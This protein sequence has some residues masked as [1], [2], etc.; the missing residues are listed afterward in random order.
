MDVYTRVHTAFSGGHLPPCWVLESLPSLP[1]AS[2]APAQLHSAASPCR[3]PGECWSLGSAR[4]SPSTRPRV[5]GHKPSH[6]APSSTSVPRKVFGVQ[7]TP[8]VLS[9][10]GHCLLQ[11][12]T[13]DGFQ[14]VLPPGP[15]D[16]G[17]AGSAAPRAMMPGL[18]Q[19]YGRWLCGLWVLRKLSGL[20]S[21]G[22]TPAPGQ[23]SSGPEFFWLTPAEAARGARGWKQGCGSP[24][25]NR[26]GAALPQR[27]AL[28]H[29]HPP[30]LVRRGLPLPS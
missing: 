19:V 13:A 17:R 12:V 28:T 23:S 2:P 18:G 1:L 10:P 20:F 7:T 4:P 15:W 11:R 29:T 3:K 6:P 8:A 25:F 9:A 24:L 30:S 14:S 16:Q 26:P 22:P 5:H 27:P 21:G